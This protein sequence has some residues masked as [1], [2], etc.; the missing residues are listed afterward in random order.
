MASQLF[1]K[2][3]AGRKFL[4]GRHFS[5]CIFFHINKCEDIVFFNTFAKFLAKVNVRP[6]VTSKMIGIF[7]NKNF[8][9]LHESSYFKIYSE[10]L[11]LFFLIKKCGN[12]L[13][14]CEA[15]YNVNSIFALIN[16]YGN[17]ENSLLLLLL[18]RKN[19]F[20]R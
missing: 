20:G 9:F 3:T 18:C 19:I 10:D 4:L 13:E 5:S 8:K 12:I 7:G 16:I 15:I 17:F 11:Q 1:D 14:H 2:I 6:W